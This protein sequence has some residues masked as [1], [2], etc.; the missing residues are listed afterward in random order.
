MLAKSRLVSLSDQAL[1]GSH[2]RTVCVG[3]SF[4]KICHRNMATISYSFTPTLVSNMRINSCSGLLRNLYPSAGLKSCRSHSGGL[5]SLQTDVFKCIYGEF[6]WHR[7]SISPF[8]T[9]SKT[10]GQANKSGSTVLS[11]AKETKPSQIANSKI[12]RN[13]SAILDQPS[14]MKVKSK[15]SVSFKNTN[16]Q[17][18]LNCGEISAKEAIE[19]F[20]NETGNITEKTKNEPSKIKT[21]GQRQACPAIL[22][23]QA[24][25]GKT[26]SASQCHAKKESQGEIEN[27]KMQES[28]KKLTA[29]NSKKQKSKLTKR[30]NSQSKGTA[31]KED[32]TVKSEQV[33]RNDSKQKCNNN[34]STI[35]CNND[36]LQTGKSSKKAKNDALEMEYD[37]Q[38]SKT[39][40]SSKKSELKTGRTAN[41]KHHAQ[42][43]INKDS[44]QGRSIRMTTK[45][46]SSAE[47]ENVELNADM[48][49]FASTDSRK[50]DDQQRGLN[51][52][53]V[54]WSSGLAQGKSVLVVESP[55]KAQTIQKYLGKL[56]QVL[57][58]YGHVRVLARR[59]G[60]VDPEKD[61]NLVWE[62]PEDAWTHIKGIQK[63]LKGAKNLVLATDPDREGEAIAWHVHELLKLEGKLNKNVVRISFTE[64]TKS[65]ISGAIQSPR[66]IDMNLVNA[67][68]AR[69]ALDYLI[70]FGISPI[71]WRKLPACQ[72][73]GRVQSAA[74]ALIC[75]RE[76]EI[77]NFVPEEYWTVEAKALSIENS[78]SMDCCSCMAKVTHVDGK[79]LEKFSITSEGEA[80]KV[81][82]K[83]SS[84]SFR[85]LDVRRGNMTKNPPLPYITSS[86]QRD[87]SNKL[88]FS[89]THTMKVAQ[90]LYEGVPI[91]DGE[92]VGLITYMRTDGLRISEEFGESIY[93]L[94]NERYGEAYKFDPTSIR[95]FNKKVKN[96]QEAHESIRPTHIRRLP[97]SLINVLDEDAYK[98]Y[99]LIWCQTMASQMKGAKLDTIAVTFGTD[100]GSLC[101]RSSGSTVSFPG[102]LAIHKDREAISVN[103]EQLDE[104]TD[105][106][107]FSVLCKFKVGDHIKVDNVEA[108]QSFTEPLP[109]YSEGTLIK[110]LEELGIG[111]PSTYASILK[112]LQAREYVTIQNRRIY[113]EFRGRMLSAFLSRYFEEIVDLGFTASMETQLDDISAG[114]LDWKHVLNMFWERF[115]KDCEHAKNIDM[116]EVEKMLEEG[117]KDILFHGL[118]DARECPGCN[119]GTLRLKVSRHGKGYFIGCSRY[120]ACSFILRTIYSDNI[121]DEQIK[122]TDF[123][124]N[125][126]RLLGIDPN[127]KME[128]FL[129]HGPYGFYVQLGDD[130]SGTSPKRVHVSQMKAVDSLTLDQALELLKYPINL[131]Q[132]PDTQRP[133]ILAQTKQGVCVQ[134]HNSFAKIPKDVNPEDVTLEMAVDYLNQEFT[135]RSGRPVRNAQSKK[136]TRAKAKKKKVIFQ[137]IG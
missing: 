22:Q 123:S 132:H 28:S 33:E 14:S 27:L 77:E 127:S 57:A 59:Q 114:I 11:I 68:L 21:F 91:S 87:A 40:K 72:S 76:N 43:S 113:P 129:K 118:T 58:T 137:T 94:I 49:A 108:L 97:S 48:G 19:S 133:V 41:V 25:A 124:L 101:L 75:E 51:S 53:G 100:D 39:F 66:D 37:L 60:S 115:K 73:A 52:D 7:V 24:V 128:V 45:L 96:A 134:H 125:K 20:D 36:N 98:L 9:S 5:L 88:N 116:P 3:A 82:Q 79:K 13:K 26:E 31:S 62:V 71:L 8:A 63:A 95:V 6:K 61:F 56:F 29:G 64:I 78:L 74:L 2:L 44:K 110:N 90:K 80:T 112:T 30:K 120:P 92:F 15:C 105:N 34:K 42:H 83:A 54:L 16:V 93:S 46:E 109:R 55:S 117:F 70:G 67:S 50:H 85:V 86:L 23:P 131:G 35:K 65:A 104:E 130:K 106:D 102:Y 18:T 84:S 17:D 1:I 122:P 4:S 32:K 99:T 103:S 136:G 12:G 119:L 89:T 111:R 135:K 38:E 107:K 10:R 47:Q 121:M 81:V 69:S 126:P